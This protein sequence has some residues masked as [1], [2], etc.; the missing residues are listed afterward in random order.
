MTSLQTRLKQ[1]PANDGYYITVADARNAFYVNIGT[2]SAPLISTNLWARSTVT[3]T[4]IANPGGIFRDMGKT[5][6]STGRV[7]RKVQLLVSSSTTE[8]VGGAPASTGAAASDYL[9]G[10]I[11]LPGTGGESSGA[12]GA[13][14]A[15]GFTP[16]ARLG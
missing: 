2:D 9:T 11:E 15:L 7:F 6:I 5:L 4:L 16:V 14:G 13:A 12:G 1:I 10:F 3:S 8:G